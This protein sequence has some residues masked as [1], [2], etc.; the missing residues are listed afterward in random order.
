MAVLE[1]GR[2]QWVNH[3]P[4]PRRRWA[5]VLFVAALAALAAP[6]LGR[7][8]RGRGSWAAPGVR[9]ADF[10]AGIP[11]VRERLRLVVAVL[12]INKSAAAE[13]EKSFMGLDLGTTRVA[14]S[15][16]VRIHY[17]LDLSGP[18]PVDFRLHAAGRELVAVFPEP[19]V[20]AVELLIAGKRVTTEVGWARLKSRSGRALEDGIERGLYDAVWAEGASPTVIAQVKER[21]RPVLARLLNDYLKRAHA[22]GDG[23]ISVTRIQ[24]RGD[25]E[26]GALAF[27]RDRP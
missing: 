19:S 20:E 25:T 15:V 24:F 26:T 16:P 11:G 17:A 4:A 7:L 13:S 9:V 12:D 2:I 6:M 1:C 8:A 22:L 10:I 23:G 5:R 21:A 18:R 3:R 27:L 14:M